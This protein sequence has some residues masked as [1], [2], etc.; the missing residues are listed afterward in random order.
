MSRIMNQKKKIWILWIFSTRLCGASFDKTEWGGKRVGE[1]ENPINY[2]LLD[3]VIQLL[4]A[5]SRILAN[6]FCFLVKFVMTST[7]IIAG[8]QDYYYYCCCGCC[9]WQ[10]TWRHLQ[11]LNLVDWY[12]W[13][14][15]IELSS[16]SSSSSLTAFFFLKFNHDDHVLNDNQKKKN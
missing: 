12:F 15:H 3:W 2:W 7:T 6:F 14:R 4:V 5:W 11:F 13:K 9:I 10:F 1:E 8:L 16:S